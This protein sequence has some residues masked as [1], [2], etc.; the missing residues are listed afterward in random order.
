MRELKILHTADL[1]LDSPFE[2]LPAGKGRSKLEGC[3][4]TIDTETGR[5]LAAEGVRLT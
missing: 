5:C 3:L 2:G 1:H 4:F